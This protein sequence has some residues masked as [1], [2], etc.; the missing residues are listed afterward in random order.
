MSER[1]ETIILLG[2]PASGKSEVLDFLKRVVHADR[3]RRFHIGFYEVID[4][5]PFVW[6]TFEIDDI[7]TKMGQPRVFTDP[8]YFFLGDHVWDMFIERINLEYHKRVGVDPTYTRRNT[9][10]VEFS[11][12]GADAFG[13][14]LALL[15]DEILRRAGILYVSVSYEESL[16]KNRKRFD[17]KHPESILHHSLPDAKMERYYRSNDWEQLTGGRKTGH[18]AVRDHQVPFA[19]FDNEPEQTDDPATLG[20]ALEDALG[21]LWALRQPAG[22]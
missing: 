19:V 13:H 20:P 10:L 2:R 21:R 7:L 6:E 17:P 18:L 14:A 16:R 15:S 11:R 3:E 5:F 22:K 4:D 12:G 1:F 9:V 8:D